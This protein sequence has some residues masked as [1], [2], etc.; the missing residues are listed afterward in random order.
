MCANSFGEDICL[1]KPCEGQQGIPPV[2]DGR[3]HFCFFGSSVTC[4]GSSQVWEG[5]LTEH[6]QQRSLWELGML[7]CDEIFLFDFLDDG[8]G[9]SSVERGYGSSD[10]AGSNGELSAWGFTTN[11]SDSD[12][13]LSRSNF[14]RYVSQV[15]SARRTGS[16]PL[17]QELPFT[18]PPT[19]VDICENIRRNAISC[20]VPDADAESAV[21]VVDRGYPCPTSLPAMTSEPK[22]RARLDSHMAF[23]DARW[24]VGPHDDLP[25]VL[26]GEDFG[27][28]V[29]RDGC[30]RM[31]RR[32]GELQQ[33][34]ADHRVAGAEE[35]IG[36]GVHSCN[37]LAERVCYDVCH[38]EQ[39]NSVVFY[40]AEGLESVRMPSAPTERPSVG[41]MN[42]DLSQPT[43]SG[44]GFDLAQVAFYVAVTAG[45]MAIGAAIAWFLTAAGSDESDD[46]DAPGA[47]LR[48]PLTSPAA[49][50]PAG[51][52]A[53]AAA[54]SG[55]IGDSDSDSDDGRAQK[56][57]AAASFVD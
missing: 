37:H 46:E 36:F 24:T 43:Q 13:A 31:G 47:D 16:V 51:P 17:D 28:F 52:A 8:A 35:D 20:P 2:C 55:V 7:L 41:A 12:Q 56:K 29:D 25:I 18:Y 45:V 15:N 30:D 40:S 9:G 42:V 33:W 32:L 14:R 44:A 39:D 11:E 1:P 4:P 26:Y 21:Q 27:D 48:Q 49:A 3:S 22:C 34:D 50:R 57:S 54:H 5:S 38:S 10:Q 23:V 53:R 6:L 19:Y